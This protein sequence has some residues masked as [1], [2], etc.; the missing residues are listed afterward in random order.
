M[1]AETQLTEIQQAQLERLNMERWRSIVDRIVPDTDGVRALNLHS[2]A[3]ELRVQLQVVRTLAR[4]AGFT[5]FTNE[6]VI[7]YDKAEEE[8]AWR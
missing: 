1:L 6:D 2:A 3:L 7:G 8:V 4:L 5:F